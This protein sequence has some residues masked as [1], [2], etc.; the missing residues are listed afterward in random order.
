[1]GPEH[2][3]EDR[4]CYP[5]RDAGVGIASLCAPSAAESRKG[6]HQNIFRLWIDLTSCTRSQA[7]K[8]NFPALQKQ[9]AAMYA[10]RAAS[11]APPSKWL[12]YASLQPEACAARLAAFG[13]AA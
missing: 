7:T 1:M 6:L 13:E 2:G 10:E 4:E 8:R 11:P 5:G 3:Q 9:R 12:R